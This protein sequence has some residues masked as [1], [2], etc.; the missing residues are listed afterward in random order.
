MSDPSSAL[1]RLLPTLARARRAYSLPAVALEVLKLTEN[2][3]VDV[4]TLKTCIERDPALTARLLRV[5]NSSMYGLTRGVSTLNEALGILGTKPLKLLVLGFS[6]PTRMFQGVESKVLSSYWRCSLT[7]AVAARQFSEH[8]WRIPGDEAFLAGLLQDLGVLVLIQQMG[9]PYIELYHTVLSGRKD[10]DAIEAATLGFDHTVLTA[11]LL[12]SWHFPEHLVAAVGLPHDVERLNS[13]PAAERSLPQILHVADLMSQLLA[14]ERIQVLEELMDVSNRYVPW[15]HRQLEES[16][17]VI[18]EQ[19]AQLADV[20]SLP[21]TDGRNYL[22]LLAE[23]QSRLAELTEGTALSQS[24]KVDEGGHWQQAA[25]N[26]ATA[27]ERYV[28]NDA[29]CEEAADEAPLVC[30][31]SPAVAKTAVAEI[32]VA[33]SNVTP[34]LESYVRA[35]I[36]ECRNTRC[37]VSLLMVGID[38]YAELI[39][40]HGTHVAAVVRSALARGCQRVVVGEGQCLRIG[41]SI[42]A[43]IVKNSDRPHTVGMGRDLLQHMVEFLS[44][45]VGSERRPTTISAGAA[46]LNLP[47]KNFREEELIDAATR[48]LWASQAAGGG[49]LKSIDV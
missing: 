41:D 26:L 28:N 40:Q 27:A 33:S 43:R 15:H 5:V 42:Y 39:A 10:L 18:Q 11:K 24:A 31:G 12:E 48:C 30:S 1:H 35:A 46:T 7:K 44:T 32:A 8:V 14:R 20:L 17:A 38:N 6:L 25:Q 23:A 9:Q 37:P 16:V 45:V 34:S 21:L 36:A 3:R 29:S 47:P 4:G 13:L 22:E 19:V 49:V 2:D